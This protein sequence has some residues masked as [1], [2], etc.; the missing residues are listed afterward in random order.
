LGRVFEGV[1][2]P[3][4]RRTS[5]SYY[6]PAA[7]VR[8]IVR[9]GLASVLEHRFGL[10]PGAA[11]RWIYGGDSPARRPALRRVA[12]LDPAVGSGAFLLGALEELTRLRCGAGEGPTSAVRRDV[13]A[14]SLFGVDLKLTAVR[15]AE[16]RLWLALIADQ[17]ESDL[18]RV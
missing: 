3:A 16:L 18:A 1:M 11:E 7:L 17:D 10:A 14:G 12:V 6:T 13:L 8:E 15:L 4:E 9:A 5:G 2:D